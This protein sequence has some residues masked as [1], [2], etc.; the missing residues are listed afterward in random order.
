MKVPQYHTYDIH[1]YAYKMLHFDTIFKIAG[2]GGGGGQ[3]IFLAVSRGGGRSLYLNF[4]RRGA[5]KICIM[6]GHLC[7]PH[8]T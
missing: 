7:P 8:D 3:V 5:S 4:V 2:G 6:D 1:D